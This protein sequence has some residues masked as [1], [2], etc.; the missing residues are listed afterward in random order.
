[1]EPHFVAFIDILGFTQMV[2]ADCKNP[3]QTFQNLNKL[4]EVLG[5]VIP[6]DDGYA[7]FVQFSDSIVISA[8]YDP[9]KAVQFIGLCRDLQKALFLDGILCRGGIALGQH[10]MEDNFVFSE[11]LI[12]AYRIEAQTARVPRIV[13]STDLIDLIKYTNPQI[14]LENLV[15]ENDGERFVNYIEPLA[16]EQVNVLLS[17]LAK[18][19]QNAT[20]SVKEKILWLTDY[21]HSIG[22][23][24]QANIP[25]RFRIF[26]P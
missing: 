7:K 6:S 12:L 5:Q 10:Y 8:P 2:E 14:K 23:L 19:T 25:P 3:S 18:D 26:A 4:K 9:H 15:A 1:M 24:P 22:K 16:P 13:V 20:V 17:K 11:G 21:C